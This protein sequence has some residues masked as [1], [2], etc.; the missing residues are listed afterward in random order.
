MSEIHEKI[1]K[2]VREKEPSNPEEEVYKLINGLPDIVL[3]RFIFSNYRIDDQGIGRGL[4]LTENGLNLLRLF[5]NGYEVKRTEEIITAKHLLYFDTMSRMP[6][7]IGKDKFVIFDGFF[8][9]KLKLADGKISILSG[10]T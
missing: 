4:K 10:I 8:C 5:F 2:Y 3:L 6:Y 1:L 7:Y 9:I